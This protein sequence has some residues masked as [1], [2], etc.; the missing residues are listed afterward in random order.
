MTN[1][2]VLQQLSYSI[3]VIALSLAACRSA[4]INTFSAVKEGAYHSSYD[5][6]TLAI[7]NKSV[8][9]PYNRFMDPAGTVIRFGNPRLENH[10]L[11]C[12][13][14]PG[15]TVLAVEDRYGVAFIDVQNYSLLFHLGYEANYSG[16]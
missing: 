9:M 10:S 12:V 16:L 1:G 2:K 13:M 7:D 4:R 5:D 11:D 14:L 15:G 8:L 6:T 3:A